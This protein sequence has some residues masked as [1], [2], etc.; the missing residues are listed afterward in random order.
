MFWIIEYPIINTN[1]DMYVIQGTI[2]VELELEKGDCNIFVVTSIKSKQD[3]NDKNSPI[4]A[5]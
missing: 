2:C 4:F 5:E 3:V 1:R